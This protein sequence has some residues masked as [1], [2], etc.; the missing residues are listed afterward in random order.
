LGA[1]QVSQL[2]SFIRSQS[3]NFSLF[4]IS[5]L[6]HSTQSIKLFRSPL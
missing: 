6:T 5:L 4:L 3:I 2:H 1:P